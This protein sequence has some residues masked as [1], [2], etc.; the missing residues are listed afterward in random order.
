VRW[1]VVR[2]GRIAFGHSSII[3]R[4]IVVLGIVFHS[5]YIRSIIL[6]CF[7]KGGF[8]RWSCRVVV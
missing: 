8:S 6:L 3:S 4:L 2:N 5:R 1:G 7:V